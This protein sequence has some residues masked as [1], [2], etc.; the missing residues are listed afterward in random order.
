MNG[1]TTSQL[2]RIGGGAAFAGGLL[3]ILSSF[4]G[5]AI[6]TTLAEWLYL[7]ID[8]LLLSGIIA[9]YVSRIGRL[10]WVGFAA[11]VVAFSGI[12]LIVGPDGTLASVDLYW[13]G[14]AMISLGLATIGVMWTIADR[15]L[16]LVPAFWIGSTLAGALGPSFFGPDKAFVLAGVLLGSG[17]ACAGVGLVRQR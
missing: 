10:G 8:L 4:V 2:L 5:P 1:P 17:Y 15:R 12:A 11:F 6:D 16:S 13:I 3:R 9:I 7:V 14:A